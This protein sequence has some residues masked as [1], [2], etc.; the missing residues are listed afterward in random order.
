MHLTEIICCVRILE[1]ESL[2]QGDVLAVLEV[3]CLLFVCSK[4]CSAFLG[5]ST[6]VL[7]GPKLFDG[8]GAR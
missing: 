4:H 6:T 1:C 8:S 5:M 2:S 7:R 3:R